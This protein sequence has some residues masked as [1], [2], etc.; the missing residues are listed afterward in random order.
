VTSNPKILA[1]DTSTEACSVA[2][3]AGGAVAERFETGTQHSGRVLALV[4]ELLGETGLA[5][6]Q[7]DAIAFGRGPGSFTGLRIGAG[8]AQGWLSVPIFR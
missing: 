4:D 6:S 7:L 3:R 5:L 2:I 8:V 1:L